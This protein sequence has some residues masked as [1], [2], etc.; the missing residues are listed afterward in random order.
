MP[1][2]LPGR[3]ARFRSGNTGRRTSEGSRRPTGR[4]SRTAT[5][6][7]CRR[8]RASTTTSRCR[9]RH[10][11]SCR[12]PTASGGPADAYQDSGYFALIR[13]F[14]R[15]SWLLLLLL[16][17]SPAVCGT[18]L[19]GRAHELTA[20][21]TGT[22]YAPYGT[23]LR[24]G[25]LGYQSDAQAVA[26]G[27]LQL[28]AELR[29]V[30]QPR[31]HR[32]L[33]APT[34]PSASATART[35]GSSRRRCCRSKTSSTERSGRSSASAA[36]SGRCTRSASAASST[37]RCAASTSIRSTRS[38]STPTRCA[39]GHLPA[40]L[41]APATAPAIHRRRS[42]PSRAI[43]SWSPNAAATRICDSIAEAMPVA[44]AA[45]GGE[46]L[47]DCEPSPR[48]S[49]QRTATVRTAA[50]FAPRTTHCATLLRCR[51]RAC[52]TRPNTAHGKSFPGFALAQS[53][54]PPARA[55]RAAACRR[56]RGALR[57]YGR[58]IAAAQRAIE[59]A[60]SVPFETYR[61]QYLAQDLMSGAHFRAID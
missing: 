26:G 5:A 25:R 49:T 38:A 46:L 11:R 52:C 15:H 8:F 12:R 16:G 40:A 51:R 28:P 53:R 60:D 33:S 39:S 13:N 3:G 45:W 14:R 4:D 2:K 22:Y 54:A 61:Q 1:C 32:D 34:R 21:E 6:G 41:P 19:G 30:A 23:S 35:T 44:P 20:W 27:E 58:G 47:G 24:M 48:R 57:A 29:A 36:A 43:S 9:S 59:A 17:S 37:S 10:G 55:A 50:S 7:G 31:A 18:F 42:P 56:R